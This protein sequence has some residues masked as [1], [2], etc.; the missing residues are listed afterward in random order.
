[1]SESGESSKSGESGDMPTQRPRKS[2]NVISFTALILEATKRW[3][4]KAWVRG[5]HS[6]AL[7]TGTSSSSSMCAGMF[8]VL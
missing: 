8:W 7:R 5:Y 2:F 4:E 6:G 1:M 3:G